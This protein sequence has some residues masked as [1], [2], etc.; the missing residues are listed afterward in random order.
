MNYK[1][2]K[3]SK[4]FTLLELL[5]AV[6]VISMMSSVILAAVQNARDKGR[7]SGGIRFATNAYRGFGD[8]M[9][10]Y[11][12]FNDAATPFK[13]VSGGRAAATPSGSPANFSP[14]KQPTSFSS[15]AGSSISML[16]H[17]PTDTIE[18]IRL[19]YTAPGVSVPLSQAGAVSIWIRTTPD[20]TYD[21]LILADNTTSKVNFMYIPNSSSA[22]LANQ[23]VIFDKGVNL[24]SGFAI[25]D[26]NWH[27]VT[28]SSPIG[29]PEKLYIDGNLVDEE[30]ISGNRAQ[31]N[32]WYV[33]WNGATG[34]PVFQGDIDDFMMFQQDLAESEIKQIYAMGAPSHPVAKVN[35]AK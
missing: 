5:V 26:G 30:A 18:Y 25:N 31:R 23:L 14:T 15:Y 6:S 1:T 16:R 10:L 27:N 7:I 11:F 22:S 24:N 3:Y 32:F 20:S 21:N 17:V 35:T 33:G 34:G 28:W 29:G 12:D 2:N 9:V 8:K 4:A 13:D 19:N